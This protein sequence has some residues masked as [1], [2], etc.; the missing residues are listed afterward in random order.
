MIFIIAATFSGTKWA[1]DSGNVI[2]LWVVWGVVLISYIVQ[3]YF[4]IFTTKENSIFPSRFLKDRTMLVLFL[5]TAGAS[6]VFVMPIYYI[7]LFFEFTRGDTALD[8]AVR[9]LPLII[10]TIVFTMASGIFLPVFGYYMPWYILGGVP[11]VIGSALMVTLKTDTTAAHIYGYS[12]L[13]ATA[14]FCQQLGYTVSTVKV[15]PNEISDA[16][17]F[18]NIAQL[19]AIAISLSIANTIFQNVGV[20]NL[21]SAIGFLDPSDSDLRAALAG[22]S[23]TLLAG[24][25][26][27][28]KKLALDAI[29]S[30]VDKIYI[31]PIVCGALILVSAAFMKPEKLNLKL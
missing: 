2:A 4:T 18:I 5:G 20:H 11:V 12:A 25:S 3:Q 1:W 15:P 22:T 13:M 31:L 6:T 28:T 21:Q 24:A 14:G 29:V 16:V 30:T 8:A 23:S 17:V 19:G 9:L 10:L 26:E 27:T 7:P